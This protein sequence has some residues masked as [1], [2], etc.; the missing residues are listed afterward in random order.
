MLA[1]LPS[2]LRR[3]KNIGRD[4]S[5]LGL[6]TCCACMIVLMERT[7]RVTVHSVP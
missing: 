2:R 3:I 1:I 4:A 6:S 5:V 7:H